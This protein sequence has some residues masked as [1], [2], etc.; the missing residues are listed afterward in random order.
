MSRF[1]ALIF[2]LVAAPA[3]AQRSWAQEAA[4]QEAA[5]PAPARLTKLP[6]VMA[7][8]ATKAGDWDDLDD[9]IVEAFHEVEDLANK[10][11]FK[12]TTT[13]VVIY[14]VFGLKTFRAR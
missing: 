6:E 13:E 8:T 5:N 12:L 11:G 9:Y 1:L 3:W 7:L 4:N 2:L 14:E 10:R